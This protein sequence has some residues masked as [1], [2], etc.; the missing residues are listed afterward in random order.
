M[1]HLVLFTLIMTSQ[2]AVAADAVD[3]KKL[4]AHIKKITS[5]SKLK[6]KDEDDTKAKQC[7]AVAKYYRTEKQKVAPV[8]WY[9][10]N[11]QFKLEHNLLQSCQFISPCFT[12]VGCILNENFSVYQKLGPKQFLALTQK[13]EATARI[14]GKDPIPYMLLTLDDTNTLGGRV[15]KFI[16]IGYKEITVLNGTKK[17]VDVIQEISDE[18]TAAMTDRLLSVYDDV[19]KIDPTLICGFYNGPAVRLQCTRK[20]S[21][22]APHMFEI[23]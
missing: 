15:G 8:A 21:D 19:K 7:F 6:G 13:D 9:T 11:E 3:K 4:D 1:L 12:D 14:I 18:D 5:I 16:R 23:K 22:S 10:T 17:V 2:I 20:G